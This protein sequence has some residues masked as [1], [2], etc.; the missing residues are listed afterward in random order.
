MRYKLSVTLFTP[1]RPTTKWIGGFQFQGAGIELDM[2]DMPPD[3]A[4][5]VLSGLNKD[6]HWGGCQ[7]EGTSPMRG[8]RH[9]I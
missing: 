3:V 8:G 9:E 6:C 1:A 4:R 7:M 5:A 2:L